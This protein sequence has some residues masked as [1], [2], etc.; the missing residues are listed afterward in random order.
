[1]SR[2]KGSKNKKTL[3]KNADLEA[4]LAARKTAKADLEKEEETILSVIADNQARLKTIKKDLRTIDKEIAKLEAK[5]AEAAAAA[6]AEGAKIELQ[7]RIEELIKAGVSAEDI[8]EK[9]K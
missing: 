6:K 1:M 5:Q 2:P 9:L 7:G 4:Q 3:I 8:L